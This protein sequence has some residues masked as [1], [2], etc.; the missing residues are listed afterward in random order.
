MRGKITFLITTLAL[1]LVVMATLGAAPSQ[2]KPPQPFGP[3]SYSGQVM[4]QGVLAPRGMQIYACID[5]CEVY[6]SAT[7]TLNEGGRY[8]QLVVGPQDRLL[9]GHP[10]Y[11]YLA[12]RFGRIQAAE[13]VDFEGATQ[14]FDQNLTFD[15]PV[16]FPTA[17][18]TVT[19]TASLP[20]PGDPAVTVIPRMALI[21]G[22]A[23]LVAGLMLL[24][25]LRRRAA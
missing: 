4:V 15:D 3:D 9:V 19:P 17:T 18:P 24:V 20:V 14:I 22:G 8:R 21:L 16:P 1:M 11:F 7:V 13:A 23:T 5:S 6:L 12:N 2:G 25:I 10:I